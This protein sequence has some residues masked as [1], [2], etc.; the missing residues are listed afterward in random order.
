MTAV[1]R[2][3]E[4][5]R[6]ALLVLVIAGIT[7][8]GG[9]HVRAIIGNHL[10]RPGTVEF[11]EDLAPEAQREVYRLLS[12]SSFTVLGSYCLVL[13]SSA[14]FLATTPM[15]MREHGWLMMSAILFYLFVPLELYLL[16]LDGK[17]MYYEF[18][19]TAGNETFRELFRARIGALAGAP[20]VATLCYYTIVALAVLQP[21]RRPPEPMP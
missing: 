1:F 14:I 8:L 21:F 15:R 18:M 6:V 12:F 2:K 7:W 5:W 4:T 20:Y 9:S 17:M 13:V 19:T 3:P 10:L 16:Y 11:A